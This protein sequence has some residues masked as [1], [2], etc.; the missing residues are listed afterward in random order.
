MVTTR[1][2]IT[3]VGGEPTPVFRRVPDLRNA[4]A[5]DDDMGPPLTSPRSVAATI[6]GL[7]YSGL[8]DDGGEPSRC[9]PM[10]GRRGARPGA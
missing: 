10:A 1:V 5:V 3:M 9:P 7:L 4:L 6:I 8:A 2:T